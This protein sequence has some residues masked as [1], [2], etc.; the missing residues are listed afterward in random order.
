MAIEGDP[1]LDGVVGPPARRAQ[2]IGGIVLGTD[3]N[4]GTDDSGYGSRYGDVG[5]ACDSCRR[6]G[7]LYHPTGEPLEVDGVVYPYQ[8]GDIL[9]PEPI[10]RTDGRSGTDDR[11][12]TEARRQEVIEG[13]D[14]TLIDGVLAIE[15]CWGGIVLLDLAP[16]D[17]LLAPW[18]E[19]CDGCDDGTLGA[20]VPPAQGV[21][22]T[23]WGT[24][25]ATFAFHI[26]GSGA[27]LVPAPVAVM[28][29]LDAIRACEEEE[30]RQDHE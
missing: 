2:R 4:L 25:R 10:R 21:C 28:R 26:D 9:Y 15:D 13:P 17:P 27:S 29:D 12:G 22:E 20:R 16:A 3:D 18:T 5:C 11:S 14:W 30:G 19:K 6:A 8:V 7:S 1:C 24:G 23:C